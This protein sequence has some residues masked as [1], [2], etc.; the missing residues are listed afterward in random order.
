MA[1]PSRRGVPD[2]QAAG[3]ATEPRHRIGEAKDQSSD[4][5]RRDVHRGVAF[6]GTNGTV[7]AIDPSTGQSLGP[8]FG[9]ATPSDLEDA[10]RLADEAFDVFR[11]TPPELR[12]AF[13]DTIA[14]NIEHLGEALIVRCIAETAL[15]RVRLEGERTRTVRQLRMFANVVRAG[16]EVGAR[17]DPALPERVPPRGDLRLRYIPVGPVAVF[18]ASNFPLAF[19]VAGGDTASALA[20]GAPVI[21]KAHPAHP[22]ISE[23]IGRTVRDA[24]AEH[25]L[26]P[27]VFSLLYDSGFDIG[28]ALVADT[29]VKSVAFTGS[30]R[31][32]LALIKIA[33]DRPEPIPVFAEMSSINPVILFPRALAERAST[34]AANFVE[35]LTLAGGQLCTNAGLV[36][37][38]EGA[39]LD[40]FLEAAAESLRLAVAATMLTAGIHEAYEAG[41][42]D[43]EAHAGVETLAR[44][45]PGHFNQG[46]AGLFST[47]PAEF[48]A[49]EELRGEIFGAAALVVQC[50]DD[51]ALRQV[52]EGLEGQLSASVHIAAEDRPALA[53]ILPLLERKVGRIVVNGFTTGVE[54]GN[55]MVHGGP[56]PATSDARATSVGSLAINRFLRPVCY[57]DMPDDLLPNTLKR[58]NPARIRRLV[59]GK[60]AVEDVLEAR[61]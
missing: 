40:R 33:Q 6:K 52:I 24:V 21:A 18:G 37:A 2:M 55:A 5:T 57:Q 11:N 30:R 48:L 44:G 45:L 3:S 60:L 29:R 41:V 1:C 22:G 4:R 7:D 53:K 49:S 23:M 42:R 56:F 46:R 17:I 25:G 34:I 10:C 61:S 50:P 12:A 19:S 14:E 39:D 58:D 38:V 27:G 9:G 15:P 35:S 43:L 16:E 26:H 31:G 8:S 51:A 36:L 59:D 32:G 20:A 54:V 13:L 28:R 47:T